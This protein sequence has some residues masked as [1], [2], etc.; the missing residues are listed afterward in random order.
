[1]QDKSDILNKLN[2][3]I[4][5]YNT[6]VELNVYNR[7]EN[8]IKTQTD[9]KGE[10][11]ID[12]S[13]AA[14]EEYKR[15][16]IGK[17]DALQVICNAID[18]NQQAINSYERELARI[19]KSNPIKEE[20]RHKNITYSRSSIPNSVYVDADYGSYLRNS[21]YFGV[22]L[23][24]QKDTKKILE[25]TKKG[26]EA[27]MKKP[28][29]LMQSN[30]SQISIPSNKS[31]IQSQTTPI[32]TLNN[33]KI[34][35]NLKDAKEKEQKDL[36]SKINSEPNTQSPNSTAV[37]PTYRRNKNNDIYN[38]VTEATIKPLPNVNKNNNNQEALIVIIIAVLLMSILAFLSYNHCSNYSTA[39]ISNNSNNKLQL[40]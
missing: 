7:Q 37:R 14:I 10:C 19:E 4:S 6:L 36:N 30:M 38:L 26:F 39:S 13:N 5:D 33:S 27:G 11:F 3:R 21:V 17:N 25:A 40:V 24:F 31:F 23:N 12:A 29:K 1:M 9:L 22:L 32:N 16:S 18:A 34:E 2:K 20:D 28:P 35:S 15:S 8:Q